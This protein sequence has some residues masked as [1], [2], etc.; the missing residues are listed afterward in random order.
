MRNS[1]NLCSRDHRMIYDTWERAYLRRVMSADR[2]VP[3]TF[4]SAHNE[5][6]GID[7][8]ILVPATTVQNMCMVVWL[9]KERDE[10]S[11]SIRESMHKTTA[12]KMVLSYDSSTVPL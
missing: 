11:G 7:T 1:I 8:S 6:V 12:S 3:I 10:L 5:P 9:Y 2:A 4:L